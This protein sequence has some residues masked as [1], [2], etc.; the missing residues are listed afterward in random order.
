MHTGKGP[1][2]GP[3]PARFVRKMD[4]KG[5]AARKIRAENKGFVCA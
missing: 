5:S 3:E 1:G 2:M 4:T